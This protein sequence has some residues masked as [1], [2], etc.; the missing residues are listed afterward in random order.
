MDGLIKYSVVIP[1]FQAKEY[2]YASIVRVV[3]AM[4]STNEPYEIILTDDQS[5]DGTWETLH[6]IKEQFAQVRIVRLNHNVG[7]TPATMAGARQAKGALVVTLDDDLQHPPEEIPKLIA[8]YNSNDV[9][10]VFGDPENRH[11]PNKQ[12]PMLV[13]VGRFLFHYVYMRRYRKLNFFTTFRLF[14]VELLSTNGGN[15]S[16]LFFIWQLNPARAMHIP[17]VHKARQQGASNHTALRLIRHFSP[18]LW[19]FSLRTIWV[20]Q[21]LLMVTAVAFFVNQYKAQDIDLSEALKQGR[22]ILVLALIAILAKVIIRA[23]LKKME[24]ADLSVTE[25]KNERI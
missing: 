18:F 13:A 24:H 2:I 14:K 3:Q 21:A 1:V 6:A 17:T 16:H 7:Q 8:A 22:W 23:V 9:D 20:L 5:T 25:G 4:D 15:W 19:Y 10:V 12:H 11:H